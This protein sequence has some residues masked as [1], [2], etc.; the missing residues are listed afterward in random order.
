MSADDLA[1]EVRISHERVSDDAAA[2]LVI[3]GCAELDRRVLLSHHFQDAAVVAHR[4]AEAVGVISWRLTDGGAEIWICMGY[5]LPQ[6]RRCGI[7]RELWEGLVLHAR[8][9]GAVRIDASE[10][11]LGGIEIGRASCRERV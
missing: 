2:P 11:V 6:F 1:T 5:V 9:S 8:E 4:G 3:K 10:E 7:Y